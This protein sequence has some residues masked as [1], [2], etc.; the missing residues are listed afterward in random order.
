VVAGERRP[1]I[2]HEDF[3]D[4]RLAELEAE[5]TAYIICQ[6]LWLDT[7]D[8]SFGNVANWAG[9]GDEATA[10]IKASCDRIQKTAATVLRSFEEDEQAVAQKAG[11]AWSVQWEAAGGQGGFNLAAVARIASRPALLVIVEVREEREPATHSPLPS[12]QVHRLGELAD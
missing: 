12:D 9:G 3:K 8:Y 10:G 4:R 5:S 11:A 2:L 7:S 1:A 6:S